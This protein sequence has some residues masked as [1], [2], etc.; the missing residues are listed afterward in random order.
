MF[1]KTNS[2]K[3]IVVKKKYVFFILEIYSPIVGYRAKFLTFFA[4]TNKH[5]GYSWQKLK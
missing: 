2:K 4:F 3:K 5:K 1:V